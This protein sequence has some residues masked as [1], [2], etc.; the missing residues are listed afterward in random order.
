MEELSEKKKLS[1]LQPTGTF[2]NNLDRF[3]RHLGLQKAQ[4]AKEL[5]VSPGTLSHYISGRRAVPD[6]RR[7]QFAR[8]L[9]RSVDEIFPVPDS[10][11]VLPDTSYETALSA[12]DPLKRKTLQFLGTTLSSTLLASSSHCMHPPLWE[13]LSHTFAP[14]PHLNE[15]TLQGLEEITAHYWKLRTSIGYSSLLQGFLGHLELLTQLLHHP[16]DST[17][18]K[19]LCALTCEVTQ[20]IGAIYFDRNDYASAQSYYQVALEAAQEAENPLLFAI[21]LGRKSSLPLYNQHPQEALPL[22][23]Q[24]CRLANHHASPS[25]LAWLHSLEAETLATLQEEYACLCALEQAEERLQQGLH[26]DPSHGV[27]FGWTRFIGY[28]GVCFLRLQRADLALEILSEGL[29]S[30]ETLSPRQRAILLVDIAEAYRQKGE[31][32]QSCAYATQALHMVQGIKSSLVW[33]R[34]RLLRQHMTPWQKQKSMKDFDA[35]FANQPL[36]PISPHNA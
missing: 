27:Q 8:L 14:P 16:H 32:E 24:A 2:P 29:R 23:Q 18:R 19:R 35:Q 3:I 21:G 4:L 5:G 12:E 33:Q 15:E 20:R 25:L 6:D 28:K 34:L 1:A 7:I 10:F 11:L 22:L 9:K 31:I 17:T 30:T 36:F 13:R 26:S